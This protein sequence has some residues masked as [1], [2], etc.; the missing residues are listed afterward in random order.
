MAF[1][2]S[3]L[4]GVGSSEPKRKYRWKV[5]INTL[6]DDQGVVWYAK[7]IDRP[8]M[9]ISSDAEHKFLG[10]T[11]KFP[12]S[13]TWEDIELTLVDPAEKAA[14]GKMDA[15][16]KLMELVH[17]SG[18]RFPETTEQ[19]A[20]INKPSSKLA[21]APITISM[22]DAHG[23]V[24]EEWT[25]NN[26]FINSVTF[27]QLDY[28][29]DDLAE[30]TLGITYDWAELTKNTNNETPSVEATSTQLFRDT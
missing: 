5:S 1:W 30:I 29:S 16:Q 7:T 20:T 15:A 4:K 26:P 25:L 19:L 24:I 3:E 17:N 8:K 23:N 14:E 22:I 9:T 6:A 13:V 2:G 27:D 12:G 21:L 18:Y 10:H 11:F 28:S